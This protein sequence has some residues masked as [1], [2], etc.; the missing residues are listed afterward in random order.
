M[1]IN[2]RNATIVTLVDA[3]PVKG[4]SV[5]RDERIPEIKNSPMNFIQ[6][7]GTAIFD[8]V[9]KNPIAI[10]AIPRKARR[11]GVSKAG[12]NEVEKMKKGLSRMRPGRY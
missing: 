3:R 11:L 4:L 2:I 12:S 7:V 6:R 1:A 8:R 9:L 5:N 10:K